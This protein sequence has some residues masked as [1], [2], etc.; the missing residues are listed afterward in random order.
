MAIL[1]GQGGR[2]FQ[3]ETLGRCALP[4]SS[5]EAEAEICSIEVL[6]R[7]WKLEK[8]VAKYISTEQILKE[9]GINNESDS[10]V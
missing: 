1:G 8:I 4:I 2:L 7:Y 9:D 5:Q 6:S 10:T 3:V